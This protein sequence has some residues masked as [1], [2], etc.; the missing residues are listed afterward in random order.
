MK[1][2]LLILVMMSALVGTL[3]AAGG[4]EGEGQPVTLSVVLHNT[5][6]RGPFEDIFALYKAKTGNTVEILT[7]AAGED[8]GV[9]MQT[10][11][12]TN[13]YPDVFEM[14]PGTKQYIK[15]RAE[16]TLYDWTNDPIIDRITES[17][18]EF[19]TLNGK[20]FGIP[21]G[22]TGNLGVYYNKDV[23]DAIGASVPQSWDE[24]IEVA[25]DAKAAGYIPFY[26]AGKTGWPLQIFPLD[27]WTTYVDPVIGDEGV[28]A[29]EVNELRLN[30]IPAF[31][32]VFVKFLE[33]RDLGL[34]QDNLLAGDYEEQQELFGTGKVAMV[35]QGHWFLTILIDKFGEDFARNSVGWFPLP[36]EDGPGTATLYAASQFMVPKLADNV[37]TSAELVRFMT[38]PEALEIWYTANPGIA[39]YKGVT[40]DLY[41]AQQ[42]VQDFVDMGKAKVNVQNRLSSSFIDFPQLLQQM[43]IDGDVDNALDTLDENY[44]V[45][46]E[47]RQLPGF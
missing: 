3:F 26:E 41:P 45:T 17:T 42:V 27:G 40:A 11:F 36:A 10:R 7:L 39:V 46:G 30:E 2:R 1:N 25:Q 16:E 29:L 9:M 33:L 22:S 23:F 47:A 8:Y 44:R 18:R 31:R 13:D 12:A 38:G 19:Q 35:L 24:L 4:Q 43:F 34:D 37:E 15:L 21:W 14:D 28:Q 32:D 5:T 20:I 6:L